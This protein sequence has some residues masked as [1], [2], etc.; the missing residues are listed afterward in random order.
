MPDRVLAPQVT[1][2]A[3]ELAQD[4]RKFLTDD[5]FLFEVRDRSN[6]WASSGKLKVFSLQILAKDIAYILSNLR[7]FAGLICNF[8]QRIMSS[9]NK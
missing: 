4:S 1:F 2:L 3:Y 7:F 9:L 8:E 6:S 5:E